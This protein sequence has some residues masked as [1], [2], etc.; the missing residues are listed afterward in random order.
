MRREWPLMR[1]GEAHAFSLV[2]LSIV[3]VILGLLTG[4]ILAGQ[5]LIR[6][7]ELRAVTTESQ[8]YATGL[9]TF[10]DK[11]FAVPGDFNNAIAFW[12][13]AHA[14][15]ATCLTTASTNGTTCNGNG[16]GIVLAGGNEVFRLWQHM[17]S[18]GLATGSY[19]G[20]RGTVSTSDT[21]IGINVPASRLSNAGHAILTFNNMG[22]G[23][24]FQGDF[25]LSLF[26][27]ADSNTSFTSE[28][29]LKPEEM[30]N[31]DTKLDDGLPGRGKVM[32]T[33]TGGSGFNNVA[34]CSTTTANTDFDGVYRLTQT[35]I[36]CGI[37]YR[38]H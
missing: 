33:H 23:A 17:A 7:S 26:I 4:G 21:D 5:S 34:A 29:I 22:S 14:T 18:A 25:G 27:G 12:G 30:W 15:P 35:G 16:D 2:E 28:A 19:N 9:Q 20:L 36:K 10:R 31:I 37:I 1:Y 38:L 3:L 13:A 11:Y 24:I 8:T 32:A 6:A